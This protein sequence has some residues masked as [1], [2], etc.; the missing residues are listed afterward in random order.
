MKRFY[1]FS[2]VLLLILSSL[3]GL[4]GSFVFA[5]D[6]NG[7]G[8]VAHPKGYLG[9]GGQISVEVCID[10]TS[11]LT[12]EL[13]I[14]VQNIVNTYNQLNGVNDNLKIFGENNIPSNS[15][16]DWESVVLHEVGHC[17]GLAHPNL[18][19]QTGVSGG[20][21][22]YTATT[23]G[24]DN[25]FDFGVGTDGVIGSSDDQRDDDVNL[26][27]FNA[28]INDP[29]QPTPPFDSSKYTRVLSGN[30][31][32]GHS[33]ATN[34]DR[35]VAAL[36]GYGDRS[37]SVMQQATFNDEAQRMLGIDDEVTLRYAMSGV[38]EVAGTADDYT[39]VLTYGGISSGCDI[40]IKHDPGYSGFARCGVSG[41]FI[42]GSHIRID[43]ANIQVDPTAVSWFFNTESNDLI[44]EDGFE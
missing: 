35:T 25:L 43:E 33:F 30:L 14:P 5:G 18:G 1:Q 11:S 10:P 41:F 37:E 2:L 29:F 36:L 27:W 32:G 23:K 34:P 42:N 31:P 24:S 17:I 6:A 13:V 26:F 28:D 38:D 19:A 16:Y 40:N 44:F 12:S 9:S 15:D 4:A 22:N 8:V 3:D 20:N 7:I 39:F 21:T